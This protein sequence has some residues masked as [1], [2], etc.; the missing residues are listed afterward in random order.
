[1]NTPQRIIKN[2]LSLLCSGVI[3]QIFGFVAVIYLARVLGPDSFGKI[4]FAMAFLAFLSLLAN[5]GMPLWGTKE[6]AADQSKTSSI[7]AKIVSLR[8][9]LSVA[10]FIVL[11][12]ISLLLHKS[13]DINALLL[14]YG[15]GLF[16]MALCLDWV[17]QGIEKMEIIGIGR[18]V[19]AL[20]NIGLILLLVRGPQQLLW[21]P[22]INAL[23]GLL[24]A[25]LLLIVFQRQKG[26]FALRFDRQACRMII[27]Q[28][29]P[30][31][32]SMILIQ[33]IYYLDTILLGFMRSKAE[34]GL[35]NAA[36]KIVLFAIMTGAFYF[37]AI[38]PVLAN[39]YKT[40]HSAIQK[41]LS[42]SAR[43]VAGL[44]IPMGIA[45]TLL[46]R[47]ALQLFYGSR[48]EEGTVAL[49]ILI[50]VAV[51]IYFNMIYARAMWACNQQ[52]AYVKIVAGQALLNVVLNVACIPWLG[53]A[54]A[55]ISKVAAE[56]LGLFFYYREFSRI[57]RVPFQPYLGRPL[58]ASLPM[59]LFLLAGQF[60][61]LNIFILAA[62]GLII[63]CVSLYLCRGV[64]RQD[65]LFLRDTFFKSAFNSM[66]RKQ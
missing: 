30:L 22:V 47:P 50:W 60:V 65:A 7:T 29:L 19:A 36:Y 33:I 3:S 4:N 35:Y 18:I 41:L 5:L 46:A 34:V 10:G 17:F 28:S 24:G 53:I 62:G 43:L 16:P 2:T 55:A 66:G 6:I 38:F 15:L 11:I 42:Y 32:I 59:I 37:D 54:G 20:A 48:Y 23:A 25:I 31:G 44:A 58:L 9:V 40:S 27:R 8:V 1:M 26:G 21:I 45:G 14:L 13:S 51:L 12:G 52:K 39:Y 61:A 63:Y 56:F 49:Q 57:I 64:T